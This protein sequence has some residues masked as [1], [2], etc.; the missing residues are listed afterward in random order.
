MSNVDGLERLGCFF[1]CL[2][3]MKCWFDIF[4]TIP[5]SEY[6]GISFPFYTQLTHSIILLHRLSTFED[7][8]WDLDLV[9]STVDVEIVIESLIHNLQLLS[10]GVGRNDGSQVDFFAKVSSIFASVKYWSKSMLIE[11]GSGINGVFIRQFKDI[12]I[13]DPARDVPLMTVM[14]NSWLSEELGSWNYDFV[15]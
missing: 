15:S 10:R 2:N 5:A 11:D 4:M 6:F 12:G 14:E 13:A 8:A 7:P 3:S 9:R 1:K